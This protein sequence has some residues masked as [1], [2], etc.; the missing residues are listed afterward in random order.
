MSVSQKQRSDW[1]LFNLC[2]QGANSPAADLHNSLWLKWFPINETHS[3]NLIDPRFLLFTCFLVNWFTL[4]ATLSRPL[5]HRQ[6]ILD[7]T[8][9]DFLISVC[10][11]VCL[12]TPFCQS[13]DVSDFAKA[14]FQQAENI[15]KH[16]MNDHFKKQTN[17]PDIN[18][19][20]ATGAQE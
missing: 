1:L 17:K 4:Q 9:S 7:V 8:S 5:K 20:C 14:C 11:C 3:P 12:L 19:H 6:R 18:S 2:C 15:F 13:A 10:H 16:A